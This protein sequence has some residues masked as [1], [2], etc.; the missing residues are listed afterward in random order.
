[1]HPDAKPAACQS[2][3]GFAFGGFVCQANKEF[4]ASICISYNLIGLQNELNG[5]QNESPK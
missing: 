3:L 4:M 5:L 1:M 2:E